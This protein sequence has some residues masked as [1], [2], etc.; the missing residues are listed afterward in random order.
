[1]NTFALKHQM[2]NVLCVFSKKN[3]LLAGAVLVA[4]SGREVFLKYTL[5]TICVF[6]SHKAPCVCESVH[7]SM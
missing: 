1:M 5:R 4:L 7:G 3:A 6:A 2:R